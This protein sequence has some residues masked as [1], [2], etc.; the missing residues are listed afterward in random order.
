MS[1]VLADPRGPV[2]RAAGRRR[3]NRILPCEKCAKPF[4]AVRGQANRFCSAGCY[5]ARHAP[6]TVAAARRLWAKGLSAGQIATALSKLTGTVV[7]R[8]AVIGLAHRRGFPA[9]PSPLVARVKQ[10]PAV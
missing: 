1:V 4:V 7:T 9:R 2:K 6:E 3:T 10:E 5:H 8:N